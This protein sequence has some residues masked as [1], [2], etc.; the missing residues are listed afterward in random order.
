[1]H[2]HSACAYR[3]TKGQ[4][5]RQRSTSAC[6]SRARTAP[7]VWTSSPSTSASAC[8]GT[9]MS[10]VLPILTSARWEFAK[11]IFEIRVL[12][13]NCYTNIDGWHF[14]NLFLKSMSSFITFLPILMSARWHFEN[15]KFFSENSEL[16]LHI[17]WTKWKS[18]LFRFIFQI[19]VLFHN[20]YTNID[21]CEVTYW[22]CKI[23]FW[24][25]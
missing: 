19:H 18:T 1:M 24:K 6:Q 3:A 10:T 14:E 15:L 12:F 4:S 2:P 16:C 8:L 20:C 22:K 5:A 7:R 17:F 11:F 9:T 25:S 23:D 13:H 21:E